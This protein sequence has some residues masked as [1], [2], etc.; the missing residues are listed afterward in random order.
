[1]IAH[2]IA[3]LMSPWRVEAE[4]DTYI[5]IWRGAALDRFAEAS[6]RTEADH[7]SYA[8]RPQQRQPRAQRSAD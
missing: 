1:M 7:W 5:N 6:A 2:W 3:C 8:R 4:P